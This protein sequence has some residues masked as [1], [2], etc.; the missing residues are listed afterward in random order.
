MCACRVVRLDQKGLS[1][2]RWISE[3]VIATILSRGAAGVCYV[4]ADGLMSYGPNLPARRVLRG[5]NPQRR[6]AGGSTGRAANEVRAGHQ[7]QD[8]EGA[9]NHEPAV[10]AA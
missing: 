1:S 6:E 3:A 9:R 2:S 4:D 7:P 10:G 5:Q 8:G